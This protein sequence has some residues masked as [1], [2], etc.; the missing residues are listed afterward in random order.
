M[1]SGVPGAGGVANGQAAQQRRGSE[2]ES[3]RRRPPPEG[4]PSPAQFQHIIT[5]AR[6]VTVETVIHRTFSIRRSPLRVRGES[7]EA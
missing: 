4:R 2:E 7:W 5:G 3:G 6:P 1:F